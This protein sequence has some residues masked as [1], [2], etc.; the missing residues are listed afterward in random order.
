[1]NDIRKDIKSE[2]KRSFMRKNVL[3]ASTC[4]HLYQ[5]ENFRLR[6]DLDEICQCQPYEI[7]LIYHRQKLRLTRD[8]I[9]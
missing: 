7:D 3:T 8:L 4:P 9:L 1:M 2:K 5:I 6:I